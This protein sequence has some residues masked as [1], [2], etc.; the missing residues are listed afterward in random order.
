M[1]SEGR[2]ALEVYLNE[3]VIMV[4]TQY[5]S[6]VLMDQVPEDAPGHHEIIYT[7]AIGSVSAERVDAANGQQAFRLSVRPETL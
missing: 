4:T 3:F 2:V 1:V 5:L 7:P 6:I